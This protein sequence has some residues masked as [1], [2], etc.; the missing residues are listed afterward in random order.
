[1]RN[2]DGSALEDRR[3]PSD[4]TRHIMFRSRPGPGVAHTAGSAARYG[5]TETTWAHRTWKRLIEYRSTKAS[6][7]QV[8]SSKRR[9]ECSSGVPPNVA[10]A[11]AP[12]RWLEVAYPRDLPR[13]GACLW[14]A[15]AVRHFGDGGQDRRDSAVRHRK[16][17]LPCRGPARSREEAIRGGVDV[18]R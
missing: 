18:P 6:P 13:V 15:P 5:L 12:D 11:P 1:M 14:Q 8:S 2:A 17:S 16:S 7:A 3:Q 4:R 9:P 10:G